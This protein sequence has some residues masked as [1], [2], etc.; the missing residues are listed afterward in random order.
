M[1]KTSEVVLS[2]VKCVKHIYCVQILFD[3][4]HKSLLQINSLFSMAYLMILIRRHV[5]N[6][7]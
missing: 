7:C 1:R 5:Y 4:I 6:N 2:V 3:S